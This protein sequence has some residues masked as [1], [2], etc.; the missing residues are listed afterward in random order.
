MGLRVLLNMLLK[1]PYNGHL[2]QDRSENCWGWLY[3]LEQL[4]QRDEELL[5]LLLASNQGIKESGAGD[6]AQVHLQKETLSQDLSFQF[7][8][9]LNLTHGIHIHTATDGAGSPK[10]L[11]S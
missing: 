5:A 9:F 11:A 4:P 3:F 8:P 7:K 6:R 1:Y 2:H 10:A